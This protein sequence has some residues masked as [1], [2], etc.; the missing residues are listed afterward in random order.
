MYVMYNVCLFF[1]NQDIQYE[2]NTTT[3]LETP[4]RSKVS[5]IVHAT[6][7]VTDTVRT[8]TLGIDMKRFKES[9]KPISQP[10]MHD[11]LNTSR[12]GYNRCLDV[13]PKRNYNR[14]ACKRE[15]GMSYIAGYNP[16]KSKSELNQSTNQ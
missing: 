6:P 7:I 16:V 10:S 15:G 5:K 11:S 9:I 4:K 14:G 2:S 12:L 8:G 13:D 1:R 3:I